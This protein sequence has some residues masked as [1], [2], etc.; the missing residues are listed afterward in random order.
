MFK[1]KREKQSNNVDL[2]EFT[3]ENGKK[4]IQ[5]STED[6]FSTNELNEILESL[7]KEKDKDDIIL[8]R[9]DFQKVNKDYYDTAINLQ[10]AIEQKNKL[11]KKIIS[12]SKKSIELKNNKLKELILY[13]KKLHLFL[14]AV[15][16][17]NKD[18][19][20]I[21]IPNLAIQ[22]NNEEKKVSIYETVQELELNNNGEETKKVEI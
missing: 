18:F 8:A 19:S 21:S 14:S 3:D 2:S 7:E 5:T 20:N 4:W 22:Q 13:I 9:I 17:E 1:R 12:E 10:K 11:L 15:T 6:L 16:K